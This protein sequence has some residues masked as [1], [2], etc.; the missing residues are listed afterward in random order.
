VK[1]VKKYI[2]IYEKYGIRDKRQL[3][4]WLKVYKRHEDFKIQTG[5]SNMT[6]GRDA[7]REERVQMVRE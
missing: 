3:G 6:K 1:Q 4:N 5:G 2:G 7:T